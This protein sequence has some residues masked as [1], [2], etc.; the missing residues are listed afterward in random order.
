MS[1]HN[2]GSREGDSFAA[3][4]EP[5]GLTARIRAPADEEPAFMMSASGVQIYESKAAANAFQWSFVAP[6]ATLYDNGRGAGT[7]STA[8]QW[9]SATDRSS[10]SGAVCSVQAAGGSNLPWAIL[11][12]IP[13]AEDGVFAGVTSIQRVNTS[14]GVAPASGCDADHVGSEARV[15]FSADYYFYKK[16]GAR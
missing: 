6:D 11:Q 9:A 13:A 8:N 12:A 14:G 16:R 5:S 1:S 15:A 2:R 3:A 10:V 4:S 7:Q